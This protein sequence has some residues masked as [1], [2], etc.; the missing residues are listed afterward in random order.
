M[1][2]IGGQMNAAPQ[3]RAAD[4]VTA[5]SQGPSEA[6]RREYDGKFQKAS[7]VLLLSQVGG[8]QARERSDQQKSEQPVAAKIGVQENGLENAGIGQHGFERL[9]ADRRRHEHEPGRTR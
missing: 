6:G 4:A 2:E 1:D 9:I 3:S 7:A 8:E 5:P